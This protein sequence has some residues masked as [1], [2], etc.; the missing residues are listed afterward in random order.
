VKHLGISDRRWFGAMI[1]GEGHIPRRHAIFVEVG[2]TEHA[3]VLELW[4]TAGAGSVRKDKPAAGRQP[5]WR[6]RLG[7]TDT[8]A[9]LR[10][11]H[12]ALGGKQTDAIRLLRL[13]EMRRLVAGPSLASILAR[14][15]PSRRRGGSRLSAG[16]PK[17][18]RASHSRAASIAR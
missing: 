17:T 11:I 8:V 1:R 14:R 18:F 7:A 3:L 4:R 2:N 10:Q 15:S 9:L 12:W 13:H 5:F 6:W 16:R